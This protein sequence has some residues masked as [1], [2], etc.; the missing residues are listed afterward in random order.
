LHGAPG[1]KVP[2]RGNWQKVEQSEAVA[3]AQASIMDAVV[4]EPGNEV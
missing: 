4:V 2:V 1:A 3:C